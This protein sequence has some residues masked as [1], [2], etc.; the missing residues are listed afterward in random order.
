MHG[1]FWVSTKGTT[2]L[3]PTGRLNGPSFLH[4]RMHT[5]LLTELSL[6]EFKKNTDNENLREAFSRQQRV[7]KGSGA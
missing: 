4:I 1:Y 5:F 2:T 6:G 7:G 3:L